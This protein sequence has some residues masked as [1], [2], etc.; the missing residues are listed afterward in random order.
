MIIGLTGGIACGKTTARD[1]MLRYCPM[2]FFDADTTAKEIL[3]DPTNQ[4][5]IK[6][7]LGKEAVTEENKPNIEFIRETIFSN[8]KAKVALQQIIHPMVIAKYKELIEAAKKTNTNLLLD[9]PLLFETGA[10]KDCD[11]VVVVTCKQT[12]QIKRIKERG[13][14]RALALKMINSQMP[15][16]EK[17]AKGTHIISNNASLKRLDSQIRKIQKTLK[18]KQK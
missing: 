8:D 12:T 2:A 5:A 1:I 10:D 9:I 11:A 16:S 15:L 3:A 17:E 13:H 14:T 6:T 7:A 18:L 4:E